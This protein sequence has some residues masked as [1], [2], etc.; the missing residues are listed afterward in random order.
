MRGR[1]GGKAAGRLHFGNLGQGRLSPEIGGSRPA[2][3]A[4]PHC[5]AGKRGFT[6]ALAISIHREP[7]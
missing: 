7:A 3:K 1:G 2:G 4:P 6:L 5:P